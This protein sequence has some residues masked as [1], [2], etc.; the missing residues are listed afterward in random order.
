MQKHTAAIEKSSPDKEKI[1]RGEFEI[2][3]GKLSFT[4]HTQNV[5]FEEVLNGIILLRDELNRQID[6]QTKCPFHPANNAGLD[7]R[8]KNQ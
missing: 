1:I 7:G 3:E 6:N 2:V 8:F 4:C 5:S